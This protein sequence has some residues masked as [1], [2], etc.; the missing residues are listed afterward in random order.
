ML[1][2]INSVVT[3]MKVAI[4][5]KNPAKI[6][7]VM[8]AFSGYDDIDFV[9]TDVSS[10]VSSQPFSDDETIEGALNRAKNALIKEKADLGIGLEGGVIEADSGCFLCNWG[11]LIDQ[12]FEPII[13]GGA[14]IPLPKE[15]YERLKK[16]IELGEIMDEFAQ[17]Q[18]VRQQEGAIGIFT[19][20]LVDRK[21]MFVHV[22]KL[23]VGQWSYY[24]SVNFKK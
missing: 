12:N 2:R 4:G 10:E 5:T 22:T 18:N 6:N 3:K 14:R 20:G 19:N 24:R 23:L 9:P 1:K 11:A 15:I 21:E 7:A 17:K 8:E 13:A 16:G